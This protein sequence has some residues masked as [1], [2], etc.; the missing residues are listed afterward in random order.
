MSVYKDFVL[1]ISPY[2]NLLMVRAWIELLK[3][4]C[5]WHLDHNFSAFPAFIAITMIVLCVVG[6]HRK[7]HCLINRSTQNKFVDIVLYSIAEDVLTIVRRVIPEHGECCVVL[8][9][10]FY[11]EVCVLKLRDVIIKAHEE[12]SVVCFGVVSL[13]AERISPA[14]TSVTPVTLPFLSSPRIAQLDK[15]MLLA[16]IIGHSQHVYDREGMVEG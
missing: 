15:F 5:S 14:T 13:L 9:L 10:D 2:F 8:V 11:V 7:V 6:M 3:S 12:L 1:L 4:I 16:S